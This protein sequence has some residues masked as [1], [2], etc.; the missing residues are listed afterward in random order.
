M[1]AVERIAR[2][3]AALIEE[4]LLNE[5]GVDGIADR[6]GVTSR[7][8]RRVFGHE[9]GVSPIAFAQ[10]QRLLLAKQLIADTSLSLTDIA[11][12]S[13]F[14][15]VRRF[16]A[17]FQQRYR[18]SPR[19]LR[20]T[21]PQNGT[22]D[23]LQFELSYRPPY[24]WGG[25]ISFLAARSIAGVEAVSPSSYRRVV[26]IT[27]AGKSHFGWME[28][29]HQP[30]RQTMRV[31]VSGSLTK[32]IPAVLGRV[33]RLFD[34][35]CQPAEVNEVL[36]T[37]GVKRPGLRVPG[38][39]DGFEVAV[40]AVLG[41]QIS[42]AAARTLAGRFASAF[43]TSIESPFAELRFAF[44]TADE[45]AGLALND[46]AGVGIPK[47]R[48]R[49]IL[50]LAKNIAQ[51][52]LRLL[53]GIDAAETI[54]SLKTILGVGEWTAQYIAM[55]AL[56]WPDAFP[57]TDLALIKA[58]GENSPRKVLAAGEAWRPWRAY[59][60]MHLWANAAS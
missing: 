31:L 4:G 26:R 36:G 1:D 14:Q 49:T 27:Q 42:V 53:P 41:Q 55:R 48:A 39:A 5:I 16:D 37:L 15:S 58:V 22:P 52:H 21:A 3:A 34:L 30:N 50:E 25:I 23:A 51:G 54:R 12:A 40:R 46:L 38:A 56:A 20:R 2:S 17:L 9:F 60:V 6:L 59:A 43:G 32:V 45:I 19:M 24:D 7:H 29:T 11:F 44:P 18:L 13:G 47:A 57:H 8:L 33:K 35:G 10:A 28:V